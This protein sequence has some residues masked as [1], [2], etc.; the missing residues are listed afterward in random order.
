[1]GLRGYTIAYGFL[2]LFFLDIRY[3]LKIKWL[4]L[5]AILVTT[6]SSLILNYRIGIEVNSGLLGIIFN[7]LLQQGASFETVYGALK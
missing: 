1:M 7:P 6:I 3:R 4:L 5:V 2:L